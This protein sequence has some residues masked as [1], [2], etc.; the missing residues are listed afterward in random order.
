MGEQ[1]GRY[2]RKI[3]VKKAGEK[4]ATQQ[5]AQQ[6]TTQAVE[7]AEGQI[8]QGP[9]GRTAES[10]AD[11]PPE[12]YEGTALADAVGEVE[13]VAYGL[14]PAEPRVRRSMGK[15][16][17]RAEGRMRENRL[18]AGSIVDRIK[19]NPAS[20][21]SDDEAAVLLR[22]KVDIENA[23]NDAAE[24]SVTEK[25]PILKA[26]ALAESQRFSGQLQD[27]LD[28]ARARGSEWGR[29]GRWRRV[30]ASEDY[31]LST[32]ITRKRADLGGREL[33]ENEIAELKQIAAEHKRNADEY[34]A[35]VEAYEKNRTVDTKRFIYEQAKRDAQKLRPYGDKVLQFA[36][37]IVVGMEKEAVAAEKRLSERL[38]RMSAGVDPLIV[39]DLAKIGAARIG[40]ASITFAKWS[41]EMTTKFGEKI[42]PYLS[43]AWEKANE[44]HEK[45]DAGAAEGSLKKEAVKHIRS[46]KTDSPEKIAE[47]L[48]AAWE[49]NPALEREK[50]LQLLFPE[51]RRLA[52]SLIESGIKEIDPLINALYEHI[53]TTTDVTK[54]ELNEIY[55]GLGRA[56]SLKKD[57]ISIIKRDLQGQ[58]QQIAKLERIMTR[59]PIPKTG[60]ERRVPSDKERVGIRLVEEAKRR[61][62]LV[63]TDP[64][65][66][67]KS[68][69]DARK[70]Y[71][72]N[73][74]TDMK[75]EIDRKE[76]FVKTKSPSPTDAELESLKEQYKETKELYDE[77]FA[78]PELTD[79]QRLEAWK[80]RTQKKILDYENRIK[81]GDVAPRPRQKPL[82]MDKEAIRLQYNLHRVH[83]RLMEMRAAD[84]RSQWSRAKRIGYGALE[85]MNSI[86]ALMTSFDLSAV[87]R[88][89]IFIGLAHPIRA[90]RSIVPMLKAFASE[91]A[92][93]A[94]MEK[95]R[96]RENAPL[97]ESS[98]LFLADYSTKLTSQEEA[99][100]SSWI[101]TPREWKNP[102][103]NQKTILGA[104]KET[105]EQAANPL[106]HG[107]AASQRSYNIF[108]NKLRADS[109]DAMAS[110]LTARGV[111]TEVEARA[112]SSFINAATGR[113]TISIGDNVATG[114]NA[115][116]FAPR[117]VASRFQLLAGSP[118]YKGT[119]RTR[120]AIAQEYARFLAGAA[121]VYAL[122]MAA[123]GEV[124]EDPR[125]GDFGK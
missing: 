45:L 48:K 74:L 84:R 61:F 36:E 70:T 19:K 82:A 57:P 112:I 124:E 62:G 83:K 100:M 1:L 9:G 113:G 11:Q 102:L 101:S 51:V 52:A 54:S 28:A 85:T 103:K 5:P 15:A 98:K 78:K 81:M 117:Y 55:S 122:G 50:R 42:K 40:R 35:L 33:L 121:T 75:A 92:A 73:R 59:R 114:A 10:R 53:R 116:F 69:L 2:T 68:A 115:V 106:K 65:N 123:G 20:G 64:A 3:S 90:A 88:Q 60:L 95:I 79:A 43:D 63:V 7:Q 18:L 30:L 89:G 91:K 58:A 12:S 104:A 25:D 77:V 94:E 38:S 66:Q 105:F 110:K 86:R 39:M 23:L 125:S 37:R 108:L 111:P 16:W 22:H 49:A 21:L 76:K 26:E 71:Y 31:K 6:P 24:R 118:M 41:A 27:I 4:S 46:K 29:E 93:F 107:I 14:M 120:V 32:L 119:A 13:R 47:K 96:A 44:I 99:F 34:K 87:L 8:R 67:L 109:F 56:T 72:R 97:Y 17:L 80:E